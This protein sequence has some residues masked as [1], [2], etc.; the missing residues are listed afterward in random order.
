MDFASI[1]NHGWQ[2]FEHPLGYNFKDKAIPSFHKIIESVKDNHKNLP[3]FKIIS[4][5]FSVNNYGEPI[6]IEYNIRAPG[7][8]N[9]QLTSGPL[10]GELT[11]DI[12]KEVLSNNKK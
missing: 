8:N 3:H 5:D 1:T 10:F 4:W 6:L 2:I 12:L 7:I 9:H 11:D